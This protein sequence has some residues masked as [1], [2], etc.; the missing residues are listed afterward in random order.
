MNFGQICWSESLSEAAETALLF[1]TG[2]IDNL[3][4]L[5]GLCALDQRAGV[6]QILTSLYLKFD[7]GAAKLILGDFVVALWDSKKHAVV[8]FRDVSGCGIA[9]Y[10]YDDHRFVIAESIEELL[11]LGKVSD[12][13]DLSFTR[14]A[15]SRPFNHPSRTFLTA[16]K[17]VPP[18]HIVTITPEGAASVPYWS[19]RDIAPMDYSD[20]DAA[21]SRFREIFKQAVKDRL[22]D[23]DNIGV[24][25]SGGMDCTSVAIV[26]SDILRSEGRKPATAF[27]WQPPPDQIETL[28][29]EG[30]ATWRAF[31]SDEY[32]LLQA[33]C[34]ATGLSPQFCPIS[35][36]DCL[37]IW[38]RDD[39]INR[40]DG[41]L[42]GEWPVLKRAQ[43]L[44]VKTILSGVGG[45]EV[46][47]FNGRGYLPGLALRLQWLTLYRFARAQGRN[48][49][50]AIASE[51]R[52]GLYALLLPEP[53]LQSFI[54]EGSRD[55]PRWKTILR[56]LA[57]RSD[58]TFLL[59]PKE[60][61]ELAHM[62][63]YF[64]QQL[65]ENITPLPPWRDVRKTSARRAMR[66]SFE[67]GHLNARI[68]GWAN[69]G[70]KRG[71]TYVYPLLDKRI[72]EFVFALPEN[73]FQSPLHQRLFYRQ[74]MAPI[75][76]DLILTSPKGT[77]PA[78]AG[79][80]LQA[81][82]AALS[83]AGTMLRQ[84]QIQSPRMKYID[85][86]KLEDALQV[87]NLRK[88]SGFAKLLVALTFI[89]VK[90]R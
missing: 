67:R 37:E 29:G 14:R 7:E 9:H 19:P 64:N 82:F 83:E 3:S 61:D 46:A 57:K 60:S 65:F 85:R 89:G 39:T 48:G 35:T 16:V 4:E 26:A 75:L 80:S 63:S 55:I 50:K 2:R 30:K 70:A 34:D 18:A 20:P 17:K 53:L 1:F 12:E 36:Q 24:H 81:S 76:P 44:G 31:A 28:S 8:C 47:S 77:E 33:A 78:R 49:F 59:S 11:Q 5:S 25:L 13:I 74:A 79:A 43:T 62:L 56:S 6:Q 86:D 32:A 87:S 69:D 22:P 15:L 45:D 71:I 10:S 27:A 52:A 40:A 72:L 23:H 73:A 90:H 88:R 41:S 54:R 58:S 38:D 68:E 21:Q 84:G 42:Y 66:N 51:L